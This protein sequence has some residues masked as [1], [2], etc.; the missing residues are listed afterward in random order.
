VQN[1]SCNPARSKI[2][3][4]GDQASRRPS[5]L[6]AVIEWVQW[7]DVVFRQKAYALSIVTQPDPWSIFNY[8]DPNYFYQYDS[9]KFDPLAAQADAV[10]SEA[11]FTAAIQSAQRRLA[12]EAGQ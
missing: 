4:T 5:R 7:L 2:P 8:P 10:D 1:V 11:A 12:P 3:R 6:G 9:K